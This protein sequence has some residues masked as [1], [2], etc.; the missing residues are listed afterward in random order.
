MRLG[1]MRQ[2]GRE[3][4]KAWLC[5]QLELSWPVLAWSWLIR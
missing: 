5:E 4:E 2:D 3:E 1:D